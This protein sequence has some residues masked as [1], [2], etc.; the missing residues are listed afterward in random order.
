MFSN[1]KIIFQDKVFG[2]MLLWWT[3]AGIAN[4]MTKPLRAEYLVNPVCGIGVSNTVE[5]LACMA[6]PCG[7]RLCSSLLWG[8]FFDKS[9]VIV[10]KLIINLFLAIGLWLFFYTKTKEIIYFSAALIGI[11]Y[12]GG[13]VALCLW[14]TRIAPKEKFSAYMSANVAVVG[15][16]GII[17]PFIGYKLLGHLTFH[18]IGW[19]TMLLMVIS[20][21]GFLSLLRHP[22]FTNEREL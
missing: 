11:A 16:V 17:S 3:F 8:K 2:M 18:Q 22:R 12:G 13:E 21:A 20:S 1:F 7:F 6:I 15:L 19:Y 4:Q 5:T 9:K 14:V 10:V